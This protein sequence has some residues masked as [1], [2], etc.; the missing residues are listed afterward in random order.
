MVVVHVYVISKSLLDSFSVNIGSTRISNRVKIPL[1]RSSPPNAK[2]W[3]S[4]LVFVIVLGML[5]VAVNFNRDRQIE[6]I[7]TR[8]ESIAGEP[9][10]GH[11]VYDHLRLPAS[12]L[13]G[14][15]GIPQDVTRIEIKPNRI[16][17]WRGDDLVHKVRP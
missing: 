8:L 13:N 5:P 15:S 1:Q 4:F 16:R 6:H 3:L 7:Q 12:L 10:M 2:G 11:V 17:A 9:V 14:L